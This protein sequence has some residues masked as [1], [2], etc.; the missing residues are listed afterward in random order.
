MRKI[1]IC[2]LSVKIIIKNDKYELRNNVSSN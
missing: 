2:P 1:D